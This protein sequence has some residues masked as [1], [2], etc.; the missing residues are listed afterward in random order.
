MADQIQV[1]AIRQ[2][3]PV[4]LVPITAL[5]I[6]IWL[7]VKVWQETGPT[8]RITL[9]QAAGIEADKTLVKYRDVEVG[10]VVDMSL[11][12]DFEKVQ[13]H[14]ELDPEMEEV[15][16]ENTRFWVVTPRV[17]LSGISGLNTLL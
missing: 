6:A 2:I 1:N 14:V 15:L 10:T 7:G 8:V 9:A 11:S 13:V 17:S 3:S 12:E 5:L 4:W 16:S